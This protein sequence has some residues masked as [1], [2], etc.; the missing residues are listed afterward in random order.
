MTASSKNCVYFSCLNHIHSN[1]FTLF[2]SLS[3][4]TCSHSLRSVALRQSTQAQFKNKS[5]LGICTYFVGLRLQTYAFTAVQKN[6]CTD[7]SNSWILKETVSGISSSSWS[8]LLVFL[9]CPFCR[10][11]VTVHRKTS[12]VFFPFYLER[13]LSVRTVIG[14]KCTGGLASLMVPKAG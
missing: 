2:F 6:A 7:I 1:S 8:S 10:V 5:D 14:D 3:H 12:I 11:S 9:C 13:L 4:P